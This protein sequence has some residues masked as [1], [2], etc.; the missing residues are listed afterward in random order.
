[1]PFANFYDKDDNC[2]FSVEVSNVHS[3]E[4]LADNVYYN[5]PL[6]ADWTY[7]ESPVGDAVAI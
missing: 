2:L 6:I 4:H 5:D 1:M 7:T 3:A